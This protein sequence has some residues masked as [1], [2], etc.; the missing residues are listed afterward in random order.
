MDIKGLL[1]SVG[2]EG[3]VKQVKIFLINV[4]TLC[5]I[6][7]RCFYTV[8]LLQGFH[9]ILNV[10]LLKQLAFIDLCLSLSHSLGL[11]KYDT[12]L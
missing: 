12:Y 7:C 5:L 4:A 9:A 3:F 11:G 2:E 10:R 8:E 6:I 1:R